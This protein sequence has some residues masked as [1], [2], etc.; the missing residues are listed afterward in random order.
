MPDPNIEFM[1]SMQSKY[2]KISPTAMKA[3]K[4][5][6]K[7]INAKVQTIDENEFELIVGEE[8]GR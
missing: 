7:N 8:D 5:R 4:K 6:L 1:R 3:N 2:K